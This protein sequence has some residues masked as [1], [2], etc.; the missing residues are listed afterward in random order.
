[1]LILRLLSLGLLL[2][3][4]LAF[5]LNEPHHIPRSPSNTYRSEGLFE[6]GTDRPAN[7]ESLRVAEHGKEGFERWVIDF[8]DEARRQIG[9]EAPR[10]QL[11]YYHGEKFRLA[12]GRQVEKKPAKFIFVFR[13][14]GRNFLGRSTV[15]KL[16]RHSRFVRNIVLYP[17]IEK[18]DMAMEFILKDNVLFEPHQPL[19]RAGRLVLDLKSA[20]NLAK[21]AR[22]D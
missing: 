5:A 10:F 19:D 7:L 16:A 2:S 14:I 17:P 15:E 9:S 11:H 1:M 8:S 20:K 6:G 13:S 18:G 4:S 12:D 3:S 22:Q 21:A